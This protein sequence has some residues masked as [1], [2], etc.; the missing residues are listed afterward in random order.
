MYRRSHR[1]VRGQSATARNR[2][3]V[4]GIRVIARWC[5]SG[6]G[7]GG[8]RTGAQG[9]RRLDAVAV[10]AERPHGLLLQVQEA[11]LP[12]PKRGV[13]R[14]SSRR[15]AYAILEVACRTTHLSVRAAG[16]DVIVRCVRHE[17]DGVDGFCVALPV[18]APPA[19][20]GRV[21]AALRNS[22]YRCR[23]SQHSSSSSRRV[24]FCP[25]T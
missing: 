24:G 13:R 3:R 1:S 9:K 14:V 5:E 12:M 8:W 16:E 4:R 22:V 18:V 15:P 7:C 21:L 11:Y 19:S 6:G 10:A 2:L 25:A 23:H 17:V 20:V